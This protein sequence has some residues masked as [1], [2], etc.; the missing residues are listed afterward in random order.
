MFAA[1]AAVLSRRLTAASTATVDGG[2]DAAASSDADAEAAVDEFITSMD[3]VA[4][5]RRVTRWCLDTVVRQRS[6][7]S[8]LMEYAERRVINRMEVL[9]IDEDDNEDDGSAPGVCACVWLCCVAV[10][11]GCVVWHIV[12]QRAW[13]VWGSPAVRDCACQPILRRV[14]K[15][16]P[17]TPVSELSKRPVAVGHPSACFRPSLAALTASHGMPSAPCRWAASCSG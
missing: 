2:D 15:R 9:G 13:G 14:D 10:L 3:E 8:R 16:L 11:C 6:L 7:T 4:D 1:Q 12:W 5:L 17:S